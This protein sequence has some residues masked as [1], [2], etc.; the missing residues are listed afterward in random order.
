MDKDKQD[1]FN[2][3]SVLFPRINKLVL[4]NICTECDSFE[5]ALDCALSV[6]PDYSLKKSDNKKKDDSEIDLFAALFQVC[7][8]LG[9]EEEDRSEK[10]DFCLAASGDR[11]DLA[12][13]ILRNLH[14]ESQEYEK[15]SLKRSQRLLKE[16]LLDLQRS[17]F[18]LLRKK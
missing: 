9:I 17:N 6:S 10:V 14:D 16:I 1:Y 15:H 8:H 2:H 18:Q 4:E 5:V 3:L 11:M 12:T 13:D 7:D